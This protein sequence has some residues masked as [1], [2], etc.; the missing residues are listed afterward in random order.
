MVTCEMGFLGGKDVSTGLSTLVDLMW[1]QTGG[2]H[3]G[4]GWSLF[5]PE[6]RGRPRTAGNLHS[7]SS[8]PEA[9]PGCPED[10]AL[11]TGLKGKEK[12]RR[13]WDPSQAAHFC[14]QGLSQLRDPWWLSG[15]QAP[16]P[17]ARLHLLP[18]SSSSGLMWSV[19]LVVRECIR[20]HTP[21]SFPEHT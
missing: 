6:R 7:G 21:A 15:R 14:S 3:R 13:L 9:E 11:G 18:L 10:R 1:I 17:G 20:D 16:H 4:P 19:R 5:T 8:S 2:P 12:G